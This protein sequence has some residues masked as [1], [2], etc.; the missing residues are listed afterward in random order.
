MD[1]SQKQNALPK[2]EPVVNPVPR[3][4]AQMLP[5]PK[6]KLPSASSW[7]TTDAEQTWHDDR[8][9]AWKSA[10]LM[11]Q[12]KCIIVPCQFWIWL[13]TIH[14]FPLWFCLQIGFTKL[15]IAMAEYAVSHVD[16]V[17]HSCVALMD[18][19]QRHPAQ[20]LALHPRFLHSLSLVFILD[21]YLVVFWC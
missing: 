5:V 7:R 11:L 19:T 16:T 6:V 18:C 2:I 3:R 14:W 9:F 21:V 12:V 8:E 20:W 10:I 13:P 17:G 4:C 1:Y 15:S